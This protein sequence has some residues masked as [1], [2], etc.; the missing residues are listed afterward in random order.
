MDALYTVI[1]DFLNSLLPTAA[2]GTFEGLNEIF[3]YFLVVLLFWSI[4]IRPV[5]K[6][7]RIIK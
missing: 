4:I 7:F 1:L 2:V 5:L 3:A 6:A